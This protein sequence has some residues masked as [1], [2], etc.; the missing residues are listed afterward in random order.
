MVHQVRDTGNRHGREGKRLD[1]IRVRLRRRRDGRRLGM[2]EVVREPH[3]DTA[4]GGAGER[5]DHRLRKRI[6]QPE[7]VDRD[8][9]RALRCPDPIGE[10][11]RC[12][13]RRLP[14]VGERPDLYVAA[15]A[16]CAA[17]CARFAAW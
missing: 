11:A 2:V 1:E 10:G 12:L 5:S 13:L 9:E 16:R 3:R 14:A 6:G 7:V 8:L 15:F 4:V 17:L